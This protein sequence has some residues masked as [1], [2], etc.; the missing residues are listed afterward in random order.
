VS[1]EYVLKKL[2]SISTKKSTGYD[3]INPKFLKVGAVAMAPQLASLI[4]KC[5]HEADFPMVYKMAEV[6]CIHKKDDL[7]NKKNYRPVSVLPSIS[8]LYE[9]CLEDQI[10]DY[11]EENNIFNNFL[12]GY[13]KGHGCH[14]ILTKFVTDIKLHLDNNRH[15]GAVLAD[16]SK[17]FD[18]IPHQLVVAKFKAY[19]FSD[20]ACLM[21]A[22]Y[23]SDRQQ[24]VKLGTA[25]SEWKPLVKGVPQG[26]ILG[27]LIFNVFIND[28]FNFISESQIYNYADDTTLLYSHESLEIV[29]KTLENDLLVLV[30]WFVRN[31]M[32]ANPDK[33]QA[34]LFSSGVERDN[35]LSLRVGDSVVGTASEVR[36]LGV[37]IDS[38][39]SFESHI[40]SISLK[41]G[42]QLNALRRL[43]KILSTEEK[44]RIYSS[45]IRSNFQYC[46]TA[47]YFCSKKSEAKLE[48]IQKRAL[49]YI[50]NDYDR[51]YEDMLILYKFESIKRLRETILACDVYKCVHHLNAPYLWT[52]FIQHNAPYESRRG[53]S[54]VLPKWKTVKHGFLSFR[55]YGARLFSQLPPSIKEATTIEEFRH[56]FRTCEKS[57]CKCD[58][59]ILYF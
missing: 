29:K 39:L 23:L 54:L 51:S 30:D 58:K 44:T 3:Q 17:A 6:S 9:Q 22:S 57:N 36:L 11:F 27:P 42:R 14:T 33:F 19:G 24:R 59:C 5:I 1:E 18:S 28:I 53:I 2:N 38:K 45:F 26:S 15:C 4:N 50:Y 25:R 13:R 34:I 55:Y 56:G 20:K 35:V 32:K 49:R 37:N 10:I 43:S 12:S 16:L 8:K 46:T 7:M 47:W 40:N 52:I 31:G 41:A 48:L 21:I